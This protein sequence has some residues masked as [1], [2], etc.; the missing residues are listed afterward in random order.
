M[1]GKTHTL[2]ELFSQDEEERLAKARAEMAAEKAAWDALPDDEKLRI[3]TEQE[4]RWAAMQEDIEDD[5]DNE[6][7]DY[8]DEGSDDEEN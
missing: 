8:D 4:A 6:D 7:G 1:P 5:F 2:H 3:L